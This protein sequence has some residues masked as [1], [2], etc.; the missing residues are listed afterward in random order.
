MNSGEYESCR[1]YY[2]DQVYACLEHDGWYLC[3]F[4]NNHTN[5]YGNAYLWVPGDAIRWN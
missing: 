5:Y 4:Y 2:G 3:R 1:L